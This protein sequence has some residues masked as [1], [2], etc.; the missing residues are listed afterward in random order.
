MSETCT[1]DIDRNYQASRLL[2]LDVQ[3]YST[4][5]GK[6]STLLLCSTGTIECR[7]AFHNALFIFDTSVTYGDVI[8]M[9]F[10][11][12]LSDSKIES[13]R[14]S[15]DNG[16]FFKVD[17]GIRNNRLNTPTYVKYKFTT[18]V[19]NSFG[20]PVEGNT[21]TRTTDFTP[22]QDH[23]KKTFNTLLVISTNIRYIRGMI[24]KITSHILSCIFPYIT[25]KEAFIFEYNLHFPCVFGITDYPNSL[26]SNSGNI[27]EPSKNLFF[28]LSSDEYISYDIS[29]LPQKLLDDSSEKKVIVSDVLLGC[30]IELCPIYNQESKELEIAFIRCVFILFDSSGQIIT[31]NSSITEYTFEQITRLGRDSLI[32]EISSSGVFVS[33]IFHRDIPGLLPSNSFIHTE[34]DVNDYFCNSDCNDDFDHHCHNGNQDYTVK[35]EQYVLL[36]FMECIAHTNPDILLGYK[37]SYRTINF[38]YSRCLPNDVLRDKC[39]NLVGI[40]RLCTCLYPSSIVKTSSHITTGDNFNDDG[41]NSLSNK[42]VELSLSC[43]STTIYDDDVFIMGGG[44]N[45]QTECRVLYCSCEHGTRNNTSRDRR[46]NFVNILTCGRIVI[47]LYQCLID[48]GTSIARNIKSE[49]LVIKDGK[50]C[51]LVSFSVE[52]FTNE[53]DCD[54]WDTSTRNY[55]YFCSS[56]QFSKLSSLLD[57]L[58]FSSIKLLDDSKHLQIKFELC[59]LMNSPINLAL[60]SSRL[61]MS[62]WW[63]CKLLYEN[64]HIIIPPPKHLIT[65]GSCIT[66]PK[67]L[68][69]NDYPNRVKIHNSDDNNDNFGLSKCDISSNNNNNTHC[70]DTILQPP[71]SVY[72]DDSTSYEGGYKYFNVLYSGMTTGNFIE[73]D[74]SSYYPSIVIEFSV[75]ISSRY[76]VLTT[77]MKSIVTNRKIHISKR[78]STT[79]SHGIAELALKLGANSVYGCVGS[80]MYRF[81]MKSVASSICKLSR[82]FIMSCCN[83]IRNYSNTKDSFSSSSSK[84]HLLPLKRKLSVV[85]V[86]TD[87]II[88][89]L[90]RNYPSDNINELVQLLVKGHDNLSFK[91]EGYYSKI[92]IRNKGNLI[93]YKKPTTST[94]TNTKELQNTV[95][96]SY[97]LSEC[98]VKGLFQNRSTSAAVRICSSKIMVFILE[99]YCQIHSNRHHERDN[100]P[101]LPSSSHH[102]KSKCNC[103]VNNESKRSPDFY[104][105]LASFVELLK[106]EFYNYTTTYFAKWNRIS[107]PN[108]KSSPTSLVPNNLQ[109]YNH[110]K[111][112]KLPS[113]GKRNRISTHPDINDSFPSLV[114]SAKKVL[115]NDPSN[116]PHSVSKKTAISNTIDDKSTLKDTIKSYNAIYSNYPLEPGDYIAS[117]LCTDGVFRP[118]K[119]VLQFTLVYKVNIDDYWF[120]QLKSSLMN[121]LCGNLKHLFAY[122]SS[123]KAF[124]IMNRD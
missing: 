71:K 2:L 76:P 118:L 54:F 117:V 35:D 82:E 18:D 106:L 43:N 42:Q 103:I 37:F 122:I 81:Y 26:N 72:T 107:S 108:T 19:E 89:E 69:T 115:L 44:S 98:I 61:K 21:D 84:D 38:L 1:S 67:R 97:S 56:N 124:D 121:L 48:S 73:L 29:L 120:S 4:T 80:T 88:I 70:K 66:I 32:K 60:Q 94:T 23:S 59:K 57:L 90:P 79:D 33:V 83:T 9:I 85:Y 47:D 116:Y 52:T 7:F 10:G 14:I 53:P 123:L 114:S 5:E 91:I 36:K 34:D 17:S 30:N 112:S 96:C 99:N 95:E 65:N 40:N 13:T 8:K 109:T 22:H 41:D 113:L 31:P 15:I 75:D 50:S 110:N 55:R 58:L 11:N 111:H 77:L 20:L 16:T 49:N 119:Q 102:R 24:V 27:I 101:K 68:S 51:K 25:P 93:L 74:L 100:F 78:K 64:S 45:Q 39:M 104:D 62:E 46:S 105:N 6:D 63:L 86:D 28:K 12:S 87:G 3:C 92:Y